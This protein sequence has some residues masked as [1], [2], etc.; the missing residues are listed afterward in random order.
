MRPRILVLFFISVLVSCHGRSYREGT[1]QLSR[2][3]VLEKVLSDSVMAMNKKALVE[4]DSVL[5]QTSKDS[6]AFS[7]NINLYKN[8]FFDPGSSQRNDLMASIVLHH[9]LQSKWYVEEEKQ[10]A[11]RSIQLLNQNKRYLQANDFTFFTPTGLKKRLYEL[12]ADWLLIYF[13]NPECH[14]C[15]LLTNELEGSEILRASATSRK[16]TILAM[17]VDRDTSLW[18]RHISEL[19][20]I[21]IKGRDEEEFLYKH[22]VYD[23]RAIPSIYLL[24][25]NKKVVLK[26]CTRIDTIEFTLR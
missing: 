9:I 22:S 24:D 1:E 18:K 19:P 2:C 25:R 26:D 15:Q 17:F 5:C 6:L 12:Q 10:K 16:L 23:L 13:Y 3:S 14:A 8:I 4:L 11:L 21:W 20:A 7:A